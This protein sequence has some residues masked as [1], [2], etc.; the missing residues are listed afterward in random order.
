MN[1]IAC[2][3]LLSLVGTSVGCGSGSSS[4]SATPP[5]VTNQTIDGN[6]IIKGPSPWIDVRA[7]GAGANGTTDD[8]L[9]IQAAIDYG[10]SFVH[11]A[12]YAPVVYFP[13]GEYRISSTIEWKSAHLVG[14]F[15]NTSVRI[16]WDGPAGGTA[17]HKID[18]T[19]PG[20]AAFAMM[21]GI[22]F[23]EGN[24][25]PGTWV[26]VEIT[27][28]KFFLM[29]RVH[30]MASSGDA[31]VFE[32]GWVN[33]HLTY[34]RWDNIGGYA[35][36][37]KGASD[38]SLS[39]FSLDR[40]TYDHSLDLAVAASGFLLVET[41]NG[42]QNV[43]TVQVSNGRIE[44]NQPWIGNQAIITIK[45]TST[46]NT[47]SVGLRVSDITYQDS[48]SM[49]S[50]VLLYRE[51]VE[52][53][54]S[55][56]FLVQNVRMAELSGILA[57]AWPS[58]FPKPGVPAEGLITQMSSQG[59][60]V[61]LAATHE[62]VKADGSIMAREILTSREESLA[63][64][65][66]KIDVDGKIYWGNGNGSQDVTLVR[67]APGELTVSGDLVAD[68]FN[69]P[70]TKARKTDID[71]LTQ[72]ECRNILEK[73]GHTDLFSYRFKSDDPARK[74]RLGVIAEES[75]EEIL[76]PGGKAVSL[77]DY[78]AFLLAGVKALREE[79]LIMKG[80]I[81]ALMKYGRKEK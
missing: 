27:A 50:D 24:S 71:R 81:R 48:G 57:G 32:Q 54:G 75:P 25:K 61:L 37:L 70:S 5:P 45:H 53:T 69:P 21:S 23:R 34:L 65:Q 11:D 51:S 31:L 46:G 30:F 3:L 14:D 18:A 17:I 79:N 16:F 15:P 80:Q 13:P 56:Q 78:C 8:T 1:R 47:R 74:K 36:N 43:G 72:A 44:V 55:E 60:H 63:E 12:T 10:Q 22:N 19:A 7:F 40:F 28:D 42:P 41:G 62:F 68:S 39:S 59:G 38:Q 20:G 26:R 64:P 49:A 66:L 35:L 33:L 77:S 52:S 9:A 67:T 29:D 4:A 2:V 73:I 6:L 58:W 76:A